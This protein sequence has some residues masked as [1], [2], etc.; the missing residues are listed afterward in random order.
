[1]PF[2]GTKLAP[3]AEDALAI[4]FATSG[5]AMIEPD[6]LEKHKAAQ[7]ARHPP[8]WMY[9]HGKAV[10]LA[11]GALLPVAAGSFCALSSSSQSA[12]GAAVGLFALVL[13]MLPLLLPVRGPAQWRERAVADLDEVHPVVRDR[14]LRL[15]RRLEDVLVPARRAHPGTRHPRS[16]SHRRPSRGAGRPRDLGRGDADRLRLSAGLA[17]A[18]ALS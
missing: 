16:L 7:I 14:A 1:M 3:S 6:A 17:P 9:R 12:W 18:P 15:A 5:L 11:Q 10:V 2:D 8:G 4:A 13:I